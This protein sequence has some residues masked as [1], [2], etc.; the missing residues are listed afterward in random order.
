MSGLVALEWVGAVFGLAG[1]LLIAIR[2]KHSKHAWWLYAISNIALL[3]FALV[4]A[5]LGLATRYA[6][7]LATT[8]LGLY[9]YLWRN[10]NDK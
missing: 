1:S 3:V 7:F 6:G 4:N 8:V 9:R 10:D 2:I 5:H